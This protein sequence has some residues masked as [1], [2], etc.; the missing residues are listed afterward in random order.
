MTAAF[1]IVGTYPPTPCGIATFTAA[2]YQALASGAG[3]DG[4]IVRLVEAGEAH[5]GS[6]VQAHLVQGDPISLRRAVGVLA[7]CEVA[8]VQ[9]EYGIYGGADGDEILELLDQLTVPTIVVLHTVLGAPTA[10]QRAVLEQVV[11]K[12]DA[13]VTMTASA[14]SR[15][16]DGYRV[17]PTKIAIIAHG[18]T[19]PTRRMPDGSGQSSRPT[20]LT[21]GLLGPGKGIEWGIAAM[22]QLV[23]LVPTPRYIVAGRTHPKVIQLEGETYRDAL[24][25]QV[26]ALGLEH[27]V[28]FD[29]RYRDLTQLAELVS[30]ADAVLLP[31][32]S[33]DQVTSGVLI[34]AIAAG[35]PVVA[36]AFPHARE[37]LADGAGLVVAHRDPFAMADAL[38]A[39]LTRR[40][41]AESLTATA[42][43]RS[44]ELRWP[45]IADQYRALA[46]RL[47]ANLVAA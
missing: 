23:D 1:G 14:R 39:V 6:A 15:L 18:A 10:Y 29:D 20:V 43:A 12:A 21:W 46:A 26:S 35:K 7:D 31:Y 34:E 30:A 13:V 25:A 47:I 19:Q 9:H 36:T 3:K 38:R 16:I 22:A 27:I 11:A 32:D 8:I 4:V 44:P 37:V 17:D 5:S 40:D 45:A 41:L 33:L 28:T 42:S 2:L 24:R